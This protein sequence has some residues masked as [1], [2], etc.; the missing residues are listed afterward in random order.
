MEK[1][2]NREIL[3]HIFEIVHT[4]QVHRKKQVSFN[5]YVLNNICKII[6]PL[7]GSFLC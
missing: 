1:K 4:I 7:L 5:E 3:I 2:K 6:I